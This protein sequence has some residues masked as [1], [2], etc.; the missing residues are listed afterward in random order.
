[1]VLSFSFFIDI[2]FIYY[3]CKVFFVKNN[4]YSFDP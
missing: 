2:H 4:G 3:I 1:M